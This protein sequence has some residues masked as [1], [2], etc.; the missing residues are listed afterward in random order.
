VGGCLVVGRLSVKT[1]TSAVDASRIAAG[2]PGPWLH[3]WASW[4][5]RRLAKAVAGKGYER[6]RERVLSHP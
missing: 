4:N 3:E 6:L 1:S 2:E 5:G